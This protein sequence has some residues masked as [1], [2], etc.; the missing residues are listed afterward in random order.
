MGLKATLTDV[1]Y[2]EKLNFNLISLTWLLCSGWNITQGN[3]ASIILTNGSGAVINFDIMIPTVHGAIFACQFMCNADVCVVCTDVGTKLNIQKAHDLSGHSDEESTRKTDL[4][5]G[6]ILTKRMLKS[7]LHCA[8][9]KARQKNVCKE[10]TVPKAD[11]PGGRVYLDLSMVTI[12][13][14][15][16]TEFKL[17]KKLWKIIMD[18]ATGKKWSNFTPTKKGIVQCTC[19]FMQKMKQKGIPVSKIRLEPAGENKKLE[20]RVGCV[21]WAPL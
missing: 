2:C 4:E 16:D 14:L 8:K 20:N 15:D 17:M 3:P 7:C 19:E 21:T 6:W 13:K 18:E 9:A 11:V 10:S 12:S 1:N 5:L